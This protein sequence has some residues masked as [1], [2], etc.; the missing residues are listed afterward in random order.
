[1]KSFK[2]QIHPFGLP[3]SAPVL[4]YS[5][6]EVK[7][8]DFKLKCLAPGPIRIVPHPNLSIHVMVFDTIYKQIRCVTS[9][10]RVKC[11]MIFDAL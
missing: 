6:F 5:V 10:D 8:Y 7:N 11:V 2:C 1:M 4:R 9:M 3:C